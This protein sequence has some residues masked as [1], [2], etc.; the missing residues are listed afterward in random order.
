MVYVPG[1]WQGGRI[2]APAG[3]DTLALVMRVDYFANAPRWRAELRKSGDGVDFGEPVILVGEKQKASVLTAV[4]ATALEQH[5][6]GRDTL[7]RSAVIFDANGKR[8]G[9]AQGAIVERDASGAVTRVAFRRPVRA[10]SFN[11]DALRPRNS[12]AG[13]QLISANLA[14]VGDQRSAAVVAT[15]G[16]RGVGR[17]RTAR[18]EIE[19]TPDSVA[20]F[21]MERFEVG[22][23]K[24]EEFLRA[25]GLGAYRKAGAQ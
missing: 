9:A 6:L 14:S 5:V 20:V 15:A 7:I 1:R 21:R 10:P 19:V 3:R 11:D 17:V 13:R 24:L 12:S 22:S 25:G 8:T 16:A 23:M 2:V 18:G 4:G